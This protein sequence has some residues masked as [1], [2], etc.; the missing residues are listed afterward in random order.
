[1][2]ISTTFLYTFLAITT[3]GVASPTGNDAVAAENVSPAYVE[4]ESFFEKRKGCSGDRKD[5]DV[6]GGKRL[7]EQNSFH[8]CKGKSKGKCCAKNSDGTG[9]IDVNKGGG[10]TCGYYFSGKCSG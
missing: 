7:A 3:L 10:E 2:K 8:N 9:G 4:T 5:S 1:M 6:C